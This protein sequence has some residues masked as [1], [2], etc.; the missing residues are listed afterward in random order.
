MNV[1]VLAAVLI[2]RK[3]WRPDSGLLATA[4]RMLLAALLM[5]AVLWVVNPYVLP[6]AQASL[7]QRALGMLLLVGSGGLVYAGV[8]LLIGAWNPRQLVASFRK[9]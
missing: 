9:G 5:A 8:G 4:P 7:A 2:R 3:Q 1:V 6:M